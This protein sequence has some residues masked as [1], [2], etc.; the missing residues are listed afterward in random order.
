MD[1]GA[2]QNLLPSKIQF[3]PFPWT[4]LLLYLDLERTTRQR[5]RTRPS[6]TGGG[7]TATSTTCRSTAARHTLL[8]VVVEQTRV[9]KLSHDSL[10]ERRETPGGTGIHNLSSLDQSGGSREQGHLRA[11]QGIASLGQPTALF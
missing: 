4:S 5:G 2:G 9:Q 11:T 6:R 10:R 3:L 8:A 1:R 7:L